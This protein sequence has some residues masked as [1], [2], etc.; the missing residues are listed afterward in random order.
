MMMMRVVAV[1][2]TSLLFSGVLGGVASAKT[3]RDAHGK[4]TKCAAPMA[5]H[6]PCRDA[7][8]KFTKCPPMKPMK[9]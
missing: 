4:Y 9:M 3:C 6:K 7:K 2:V 8:G 1:A 5:K